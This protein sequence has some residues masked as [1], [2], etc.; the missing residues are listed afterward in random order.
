MTLNSVST[1]TWRV[2]ARQSRTIFTL[3]SISTLAFVAL[4]YLSQDGTDAF[5]PE[6]WDYELPQQW[7]WKK[8]AKEW[9]AST[10]SD[11]PMEDDPFEIE[12]SAHVWD[13][14]CHEAVDKELKVAVYD[15]TPFH[16]GKQLLQE[17]QCVANLCTRLSEVV[18]SILA[19]LND[20]GVQTD[21]YR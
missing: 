5:L 17:S 3:T 1:K 14:T 15:W 8:L 9:R 18:G 21:M 6:S 10:V 16:E 13:N 4:L 2:L 19:S 12:E 11:V 20:T 7:D